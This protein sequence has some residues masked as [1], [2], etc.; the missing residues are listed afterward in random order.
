MESPEGLSFVQHFQLH[1]SME[2]GALWTPASLKEAS[3]G[4]IKM[5][6]VWKHDMVDLLMC[7]A[8]MW[9]WR[10]Q[11]GITRRTQLCAAFC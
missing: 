4:D 10:L 1:A 6:Q 8:F 2:N 11:H 9:W 7:M 3:E 5:T